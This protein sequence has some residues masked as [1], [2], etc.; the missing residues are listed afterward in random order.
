MIVHEIISTRPT[1]WKTLL[2]FL[3]LT[4][5]LSVK[6]Q[7][8]RGFHAGFSIGALFA[9]NYSAALY[10]GYGFDR[11]GNRNDFSHSFMYEK[12]INQ[13]GGGYGQQDQIATALNVNPGEWKFDQSDMPFNMNYTVAIQFGLQT[14]YSLNK[15]E[16]IL[17]NALA[18]KLAVTGNFTITTTNSLPNGSLSGN[19]RTFPI[20]GGEQRLVLQ[21]GY[22][23]ILGDDPTFN[24]FIEA[25]PSLTLVKFDKNQVKINN[26]L[27]DL[28]SG[29]SQPNY[30]TPGARILTGFGM[31]AFAGIGLNIN[32]NSKWTAQLLYSP[33]YELINIGV[34]PAYTLQNSLGL[35]AYYNL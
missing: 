35:R 32:T 8:E 7:S 9:N 16:A 18:S 5:C 28:T 27:I 1:I 17:F 34:G 13:Y 25:G 30:V 15:N 26:L 31:G 19:I 29:Y 33:S 3:V 14:K 22:Q 24:L 20:L 2:F 10:D 12:I 4:N 11:A 6:G 21:T 23:R